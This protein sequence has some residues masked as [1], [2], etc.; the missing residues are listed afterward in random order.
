MSKVKMLL[1]VVAEVQKEAPEDV[2][3]FSKRYAEAKVNLQNQIAKG[4]MLPRGV[5][6]HPLE[7]FAFNYSVQRDV[8]PGHVMNIMKKFDPRV[9][10]PVSAVKR[11][12]SDTLYIFDGQH[13]AVTLAMLGYEKIPVTIV[14]TDEVAFDAEAFEIVNDSGILR[15]GTEEIHRCLLHRF[16]M[17]EIE[18]ERV[19][20]AHQVQEVF[21]TVQIDLEPKRVRKSTGKCGPNKYYFSHFDYAYKGY[22]MAGAEGLQKALEAIKLVYGEEDG[23]EINQG[24]FIGLMKQYQMGNEAKRLKRLPENWMIKMLESLKQGCGASATLIHSASKKQWQH[25][26][27]VGWDAPVAMAHVLREVYL[28]ED[29]EFEPSY[30]PNV[31][32]KLFDGDIASDSEATTAFNKYLHNRKEVA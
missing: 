27:G 12:D 28:I 29:G 24:L 32:L 30:M 14:E 8:R 6:E 19:V 20:T 4:R 10:T 21:D 3:N 31:T 7:D 11:S 1:D 18:T 9:C 2:P 26:N 15:A 25:A 23:G 5:E 16:K 13:R 22:K 17:G